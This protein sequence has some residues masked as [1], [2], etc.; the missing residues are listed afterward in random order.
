MNPALWNDCARCGCPWATWWRPSTGFEVLRC[1][2]ARTQRTSAPSTPRW[3]EVMDP[4]QLE[5][6]ARCG[7]SF[8]G[9][10]V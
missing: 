6:C 8:V 3:S 2:H 1:L 4:R 9:A 5:R 10:P 7:Y